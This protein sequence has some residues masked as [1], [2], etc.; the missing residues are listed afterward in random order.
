MEWEVEENITKVKERVEFV[1][2][3]CKCKTG[4]A[5]KR[6][7]C[8]KNMHTC[9]PGCECI[10]CT[11]HLHTSP[12]NRQQETDE[13]LI[14]LE[15]EG[16]IEGWEGDEYVEESDED[17]STHEDEELNEVMEF[18]FGEEDD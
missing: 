14:Q 18:V 4:C 15:V 3:G 10:N 8:K 1:L 11:N 5:T 12:S 9:G 7:K 13:E 6:C 16:N 17:L 2:N